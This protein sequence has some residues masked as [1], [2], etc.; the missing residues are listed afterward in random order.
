M[1]SGNVG[2]QF[3][4]VL[5]EEE[6]LWLYENYE[7][8]MQEPIAPSEKFKILQLL[9]RTEE[10][11]K[12]LQ[13]RFATHKR[14]SS[15]GSEAITVALNSILAEASL[16]DKGEMEY[17]VLGMPHRGRLATLVVVNDLPF[18]NLVYKVKGSNEIPEEINDRID[19][20]PTHIA[21]SNTK[22]FSLGGDTSKNR[23]VTLTMLHNP[24][25]LESQNSISMGKTK[26]KQDDFGSW[27]KVL[28]IQGHGDAAF[29][30]QGA[31]YEALTLC[32]LPKFSCNGTIHFITNNQVGFTTDSSD[33]RSFP[34]ACDM[35]KP[36]GIPILRVNAH[37]VE[38]VSKVCKFA[39]RYW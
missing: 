35:V 23:D 26:A 6:R 28:N 39:V 2:V 32:K 5:G 27:R 30:G 8:A 20:M 1:Y 24:S 29:T 38:S 34:Y 15:E 18:R 12:F 11:E 17:A 14:Y 13:K 37:D 25:H 16:L 36:F 22:R 3:E 4:H 19:D 33:A 31:A 7:Q 21:V 9:I 10:M